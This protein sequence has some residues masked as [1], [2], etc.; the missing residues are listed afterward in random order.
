MSRL[1]AYEDDSGLRVMAADVHGTWRNTV[2]FKAARL[3][4]G[5]SGLSI[6]FERWPRASPARKVLPLVNVAD[7]REIKSLLGTRLDGVVAEA[8]DEG[9][10][11]QANS[12]EEV[13]VASVWISVACQYLSMKNAGMRG[14]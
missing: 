12:V 4:R 6:D 10:Q 9:L 7:L 5:A 2:S 11:L 13:E 14:A 3:T 1:L 8:C